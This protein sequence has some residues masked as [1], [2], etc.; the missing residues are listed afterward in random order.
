MSLAAVQRLGRNHGR[1]HG[2]TIDIAA[3]TEASLAAA[4]RHGW[5][6]TMLDAAGLPLPALTRGARGPAGP[7]RRLY[8]STGIHGDEPAGPLAVRQLLED[9]AFPAEAGLWLCPCLNPTG[10]PRSTRENAAGVDLNRDYRN[11][12][13]PEVRAHLAW[14][15]AQPPFDAAFCLHEDWEAAGFYV[16]ELNPDH[17]PSLAETMVVA[18]AK[19]C[20][21]DPSELIDGREAAGGIIRPNLD[22]AQRPEWP[23]AFYLGQRKTRLGYTLEAPSDFPLAV[24][25]AA[26]VAGMRAALAA[27]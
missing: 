17:R 25:V 7:A 19:V 23:E 11:P 10:F 6:V 22:P 15:E 24:R 9:D 26:L 5:S 8:V 20:P 27:V 13:T 2:E 21:I 12:S 18:V 14:L 3:V 4:R 16:Y 1:Y